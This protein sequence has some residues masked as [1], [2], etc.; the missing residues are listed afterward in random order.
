MKTRTTFLLCLCLFGIGAVQANQSVEL[1]HGVDHS[2][3][4][5]PAYIITTATTTYFLDK[6]GGG[7]SSIVDNEGVDWL[8]FHSEEGSGWKGEY[9]G[10]PN[11]IHRQ[12]G[13]YFHAMNAGTDPSNSVVAIAS[14]DHLRIVFTSDNGQW[15]GRWDFYPDRCDFTMSKV[16][17]GYKY[18]VLYEGVPGGEMNETD[19]WYASVDDKKHLINESFKGD[20]PG[21]EWIAFGDAKSSRMIYILNHE[22]DDA[23]DE[24]V[25]RPYMTVLGFGRSDKDKFLTT[26]KTFSIGFVEST[27]YSV[28]AQT[29]SRL[30][31]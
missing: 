25:S 13:S 29:I 20:F 27:E 31:E 2:A 22:D 28:V 5:G 3:G 18:W 19:F 26:P 10:F 6:D 9:R 15:E 16:S 30:V 23:L 8:G 4:G 12:D 14:D 11:A 7:L 24:F 1:T 17:E 21:P